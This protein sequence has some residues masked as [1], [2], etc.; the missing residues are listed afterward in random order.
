MIR[1]SE[2]DDNVKQALVEAI[3]K[4]EAWAEGPKQLYDLARAAIALGA[5]DQLPKMKSMIHQHATSREAMA[6]SMAADDLLALC[7][8]WALIESS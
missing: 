8:T 3:S 7:D 6:G 2:T 5:I 1:T 4:A